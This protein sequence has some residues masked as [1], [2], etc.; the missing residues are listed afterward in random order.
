MAD[1]DIGDYMR[2]LIKTD[3]Y[4]SIY[5][6]EVMLEAENGMDID[7]DGEAFRVGAGEEYKADSGMDYDRVIISTASNDGA[8]GKIHFKNLKRNS[9]ALYSGQLELIFTNKG[10]VVINELP[11]EDYLCGVIPSEMPSTYPLEALKAQ[12]VSAR[13]YT[14]YHMENYAYP[15]WEAYMDDST[16]YQVYMNNA[17]DEKSTQAV[18]E[19]EGV[20]ITYNE[21]VVECF[22]Y[23]TS[24]GYNND[25]SN[26][27]DYRA[28]ID[29]GSP[30]DVEYDEAW[31]RWTYDRE[32][33]ENDLYALFNMI[34]EQS[35]T[36]PEN[37]VIESDLKE[38]D[39]L[40]YETKISEI[41]IQNRE[42]SGLVTSLS[43]ITPNYKIIIS[44]QY[45]IRMI[46]GSLGGNVIRKDGSEYTLNNMLPS[47]YFYIDYINSRLTIHGAGFGHG[48][49]MSQNGAKKLAESGMD[50]MQILK[51]YYD[52]NFRSS[53]PNTP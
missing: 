41:T 16:L 5:H 4:E 36:Q 15:E 48:F 24:G 39:G 7:V 37:V 33:G 28:Y 19:T 42:K 23:S 30:D 53:T 2:V 12:A 46:L 44:T 31:Y 1:S 11:I 45:I 27:S 3:N 22:Y 40:I 29:E 9:T 52:D 34:Y 32:L 14:Y 13:T 10:I 51:Y 17:P 20:V 25:I 18:R 35:L 26:E 6:S 8:N 50:Y 47:A 38:T 43:V 49:G 21:E